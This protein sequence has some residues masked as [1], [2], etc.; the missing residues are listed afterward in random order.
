[1]KKN[2]VELLYKCAF[3]AIAFIEAYNY[4]ILLLEKL[5]KEH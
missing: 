5:G 1:M 3:K 2:Y 4:F